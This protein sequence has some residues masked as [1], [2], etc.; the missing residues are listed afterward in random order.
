MAEKV[1]YITKSEFLKHMIYEVKEYAEKYNI[2]AI[3][4]LNCIISQQFDYSKG[5]NIKSARLTKEEYTKAFYSLITGEI[6]YS[7][8]ISD[9]YM[10]SFFAYSNYRINDCEIDNDFFNQLVKE[11]R[12]YREVE[13]HLKADS[14]IVRL[15][16]IPDNLQE[17]YQLITQYKLKGL[18]MSIIMVHLYNYGFIQGVRSE[19]A[20]RK[21]NTIKS[22]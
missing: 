9:E 22:A 10:D 16:P 11:I 21:K 15:H 20:R 18:D 6:A 4:A 2:D 5:R 1:T 13:E 14:S 12:E 17:I 19:R 8:F 7:N 3:Q